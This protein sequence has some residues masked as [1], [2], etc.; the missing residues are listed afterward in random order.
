MK[1]TLITAGLAGL[2]V[3]G[4]AGQSFAFSDSGSSP[5]PGTG[6]K[7]HAN[8][9]NCNSYVDKCSFKTSAKVKKG[10]RKYK[11]TKIRNV[12][13]VKANGWNAT[14]SVSPSAQQISENTA[15][16][17]W[18]NK[19]TWISDIS[20]IA[21]PSGSMNTS[22]TTCSDAAAFK[23]GVKGFASACAND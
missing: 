23:S 15:R 19:R 17:R 5:L 13:T 21:D 10:D 14:I 7:V 20:G 22:I 1:K 4:A 11:V 9:W 12:A 3:A 2:M 16:I 6:A 18:T 8:A